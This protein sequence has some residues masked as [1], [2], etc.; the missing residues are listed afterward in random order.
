MQ[1]V[2]GGDW[3]RVTDLGD[4]VTLIEEPYAGS[5]VSANVWH[6]RG[7]DRDLVVDAGLGVASL[8]AE[9]PWLF[10]HEPVLVLS[11]AHLDHMGGA[12]EFRDVR[13]HSAEVD[14]VRRPGAASLVTAV[15]LELLGL[16][17]EAEGGN[18]PQ[19]LLDALPDENFDVAAYGLVP[20]PSASAVTEADVI[21]LGDRTFSVLH[22]PGHTPGSLS[23]LEID[24]GSL[25]T[26]DV[27]YEGG[28]IDSCVGSDPA[29]YQDTMRRLLGL[30]IVRAFP[31]H[32]RVLSPSE[33][34]SIASD[35]LR[36]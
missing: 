23:V 15:E 27:L 33:M 31:G 5:L 17:A 26:G 25:F 29:A 16:D 14:A 2:G 24:S 28:L 19:L 9:V 6:V 30:D 1:I 11:H 32:G 12:H 35:Y 7:R 8:M 13:V 4:G 22:L 36:A 20:V 10:E 3:F 34:R 21:D 18:L